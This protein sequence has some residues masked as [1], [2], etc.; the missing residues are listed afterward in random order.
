MDDYISSIPEWYRETLLD[1]Q[2]SLDFLRKLR[3]NEWFIC[4]GCLKPLRMVPSQFGKQHWCAK[5]HHRF[6]DFSGTF[7]NNNKLPWSRVILGAHLFILGVSANQTAKY[8]E[9]NYK[10]ILNLFHNIRL[11]ISIYY[12]K[13]R[14]EERMFFK[15]RRC[16]LRPGFARYLKGKLESYRHISPRNKVLYLMEQE[17]RYNEKNKAE[18]LPHLLSY[19]LRDKSHLKAP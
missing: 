6:Y 13:C 18:V 10:S 7:L 9:V 17:F 16:Y 4:P 5:C 2:K 14:K 8:L 3:L 19:L 11:A 12:K 15:G 1:D